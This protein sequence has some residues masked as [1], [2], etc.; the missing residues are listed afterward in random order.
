MTVLLVLSIIFARLASAQIACR[1]AESLIR[2]FV[3]ANAQPLLLHALCESGQLSF[4]VVSPH[5]SGE[6]SA[7]FVTLVGGTYA[8][9]GEWDVVSLPYGGGVLLART[10]MGSTLTFHRFLLNATALDARLQLVPVDLDIDRSFAGLQLRL[11]SAAS[12]FVIYAGNTDRINVL[13]PADN[14]A[15]RTTGASVGEHVPCAMESEIN[16]ASTDGDVSSG[17]NTTTTAPIIVGQ[18]SLDPLLS[19]QF[20]GAA[21]GRAVPEPVL[22]YSSSG[23]GSSCLVDVGVLAWYKIDDSLTVAHVRSPTRLRFVSVDALAA[24]FGAAPHVALLGDQLFVHQRGQR[25]ATSW[26]R[27]YLPGAVSVRGG[28]RAR[29]T[30]WPFTTSAPLDATA[31]WAR[32]ALLVAPLIG[33]LNDDG[34]DDV[35][36]VSAQIGL[37]VMHTGN[38]P[39]VARALCKHVQTVEGLDG[40]KVPGA[41]TVAAVAAVVA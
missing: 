20:T 36:L 15:W 3:N 40:S 28:V 25:A 12:G 32:Q 4:A 16:D 24:S 9:S 23:A 1:Q 18:V 19:V 13:T 8:A 6:L 35:V 2:V 34:A 14:G 22:L 30:P 29:P 41:R 31:V 21:G 38:D 33:D 26:R 11:A 17:N 5:S 39:V 10:V 27:V 37:Q 7:P